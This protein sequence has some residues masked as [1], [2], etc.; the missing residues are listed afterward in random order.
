MMCEQATLRAQLFKIT[1]LHYFRHDLTA[2]HLAKLFTLVLNGHSVVPLQF[3]CSLH[4][5]SDTAT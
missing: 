4:H 3:G 2:L 5:F 1:G